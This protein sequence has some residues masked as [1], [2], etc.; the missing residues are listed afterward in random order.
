M[1]FVPSYLPV[2]LTVERIC[3]INKMD[4]GF[5]SGFL[6]IPHSLSLCLPLYF[7]CS[8]VA[9]SRVAAFSQPELKVALNLS[10]SLWAFDSL[11]YSNRDGERERVNGS[12]FNCL[13]ILSSH[14]TREPK[15]HHVGFVSARSLSLPPCCRDF[16][17]FFAAFF[18]FFFASAF[19]WRAYS[20]F[21]TCAAQCRK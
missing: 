3:A 13:T 8:I 20:N 11:E 4:F 6:C 5:L 9:F 1:A 7:S 21:R 10:P 17:L 12:A 18:R 14:A 2:C 19:C 16:F 15:N